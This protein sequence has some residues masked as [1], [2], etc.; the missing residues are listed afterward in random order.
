M[1]HY[2]VGNGQCF[3]SVRGMIS[4]VLEIAVGYLAVGVGAGEIN[5]VTLWDHG[6]ASGTRP[7]SAMVGIVRGSIERDPSIASERR[8]ERHRL[9]SYGGLAGVQGQ[10]LRIISNGSGNAVVNGI[11]NF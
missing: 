5:R 10:R 1:G 3:R 4:V 8:A 9:A 7:A 2:G 11:R 6:A